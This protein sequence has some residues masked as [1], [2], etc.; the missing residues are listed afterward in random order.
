MDFNIPLATGQSVLVINAGA[1]GAETKETLNYSENV[2]SCV[3]STGAVR[4]AASSKLGTSNIFLMLMFS[5]I[6]TFIVTII[7]INNCSGVGTS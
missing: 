4:I 3:G 6:V 1:E 2:S 5:C 7:L